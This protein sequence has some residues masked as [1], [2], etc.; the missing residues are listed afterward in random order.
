[1]YKNCLWFLFNIVI[2]QVHSSRLL[3]IP[4]HLQ[5]LQKKI[6]SYMLSNT[7]LLA[8]WILKPRVWNEKQF[9]QRR[10]LASFNKTYI[11]Q[12][13]LNS[14]LEEFVCLIKQMLC[15]ITWK[16]HDDYAIVVA[17]WVHRMHKYLYYLC[18]TRILRIITT[19]LQYT[20]KELLP[21]LDQVLVII[22]IYEGRELGW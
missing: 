12:T 15:K 1:M 4:V 19:F 18:N 9:W 6:L 7:A 2:L 5:C 17:S 20:E 21:S 8:L 13:S 14:I 11:W 22:S 10:A 3:N 16:P